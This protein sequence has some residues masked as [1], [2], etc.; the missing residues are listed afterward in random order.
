M[1]DARRPSDGQVGDAELANPFEGAYATRRLRANGIELSCADWNPQGPA[2]I[3]LVHGLHA[4]GH[5][6]DPIAAELARDH[7]VL[8]PDLRGHGD[9][10]WTRD[11]GYWTRHFV[12]DLHALLQELNAGPVLYVG[13]SLGARIG[14]VYGAEQPRGLRGMLLADTAPETPKTAARLVSRIVGGTGAPPGFRTR[15]EARDHYAAAYPEWQ[16]VFHLLYALHQL[17]RNWADRFVNKHDPD[18]YWITRSAGLSEVPYLWECA[19][20][21]AVPAQVIWGERS[22]YLDRA[23]LDRVVATMPRAEPVV[24]PAGHAI[25]REIPDAFTEQI[26][27]FDAT[28]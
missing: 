19:A 18:L 11:Q 24:L 3:L 21:A 28:L 7:R 25:P 17:R 27:R 20:R 10:A 26:R 15:G 12:A 4:Q 6:W 9:S 2:T 16:P 13:H 8:C 22:P 14:Y 23:M 5:V 1:S